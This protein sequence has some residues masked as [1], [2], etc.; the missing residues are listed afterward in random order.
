M[1]FIKVWGDILELQKIVQDVNRQLKEIFND[2]SLTPQ[3]RG[4]KGEQIIGELLQ[5]WSSMYD[6][7]IFEHSFI[8]EQGPILP[9]QNSAETNPVTES[10]FI[11]V[12]P[13]A[14]FV[15]EVKTIYGQMKVYEDFNI[16]IIRSGTFTGEN[17]E[18]KN[19]FRQNEMHCRHLYYHLH[20]ILP[21]GNPSY[22]KPILVMTGKMK[23][24]DER[25]SVDKSKYPITILN[26]LIPVLEKYNKPNKYLLD[27]NKIRKRFDKIRVLDKN[28]LYNSQKF[29]N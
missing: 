1:K 27:L 26:K 13:Y 4:D 29:N 22:I 14:V 28:R 15:I 8:Y 3:E 2:T 25:S 9:T 23:I 6:G 10:D 12:T 11:V 16:E 21:E 17:F 7:S 24:F 20:D 19:F 5:Y 18:S